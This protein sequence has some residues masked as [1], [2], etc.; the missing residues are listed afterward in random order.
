MRAEYFVTVSIALVRIFDDFVNAHICSKDGLVR[1]NT[2]CSYVNNLYL[3]AVDED[4]VDDDSGN[5]R[6]LKRVIE[7]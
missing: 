3:L 6:A 1:G 5:V 4:E 2:V 7:R